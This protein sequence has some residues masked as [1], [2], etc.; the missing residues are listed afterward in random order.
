MPEKVVE[1]EL[2]TGLFFLFSLS[3]FYCKLRQ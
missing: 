2:Y 1:D 3:L